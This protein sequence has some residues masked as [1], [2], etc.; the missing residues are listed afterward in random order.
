MYKFL[1]SFSNNP[2]CR[3]DVRCR[4]M[5]MFSKLFKMYTETNPA[6]IGKTFDQHA[7]S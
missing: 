7:T 5:T 2:M 4:E 3:K 1:F 6:Y